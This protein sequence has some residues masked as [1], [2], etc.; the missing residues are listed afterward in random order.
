MMSFKEAKKYFD[1]MSLRMV[2]Y[3]NENGMEGTR[4]VMVE[5]KDRDTIGVFIGPEGG[6]DEDEIDVLRENSTLISLGR[7]ILRTDTAPICTMSMIM[8]NLE[9]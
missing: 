1:T 8:M 7:R 2:P 6:F 4:K 9:M 3:E 5:L